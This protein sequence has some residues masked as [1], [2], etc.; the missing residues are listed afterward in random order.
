MAVLLVIGVMDLR[1]M[2]VVAVA[3]T[4]ERLAPAAERVA[5][6][7]GAVGVAYGMFLIVRAVSAIVG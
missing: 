6:G 4:V 2:T 7:V 3:I 1:T 5:R